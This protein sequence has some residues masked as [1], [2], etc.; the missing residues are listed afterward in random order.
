MQIATITVGSQRAAAAATL[1]YPTVDTPPID[2]TTIVAGVVGHKRV[3]SS[4][5]VAPPL[6]AAAASA[7]A[8]AASSTA[9]SLA[10]A[11]A[12]TVAAANLALYDPTLAAKRYRLAAG[13]SPNFAA[14][15]YTTYPYIAV[16]QLVMAASPLRPNLL[17]NAGGAANAS[18]SL[19]VATDQYNQAIQHYKNEAIGY[20]NSQQRAQES[21]SSSM[22]SFLQNSDHTVGVQPG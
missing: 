8:A 2:T 22:R 14:T 9:D 13:V 17:G 11:A 5:A 15:A 3:A 4:A 10:A 18:P 20:H 19:V 7:A 6:T 1:V 16:P 21:G 12:A